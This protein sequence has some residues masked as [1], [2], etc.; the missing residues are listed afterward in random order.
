MSKWTTAPVE[1]DLNERNEIV[2]GF[3]V[4]ETWYGL[5]EFMRAQAGDDYDGYL[6]ITNTGGLVIR[7]S[8][9]GDS[10]EYQFR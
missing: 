4:G 3:N 2:P 9:D 6:T 10:V 7:L 5:D 1:Y 8:D